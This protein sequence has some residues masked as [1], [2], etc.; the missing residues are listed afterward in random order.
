ML[1]LLV[2][3]WFNNK[4]IT[5][6]G[7]LLIIIPVIILVPCFGVIPFIVAIV[8]ML[9]EAKNWY[10]FERLLCVNSNDNCV[11]GSV[12]HEPEVST[13][14]DRKM[15][16]LLAPFTEEECFKKIATHLNANNVLLNNPA[17]FNNPP[18][19]TGLVAQAPICDADILEDP[20]ADGAERRAERK[21]IA[22]YL[23]IIKGTDPADGDAT[24]NI[25]NNFLVGYMDRLLDPG[26]TNANGEPKN[27]QGRYYRKD[28]AII[29]PGSA[30]SEAIPPDY[31]SNISWQAADSSISPLTKNNP[32]E[33]TF[34]PRGLNTMFRFDKD[35]LL[36]YLHC[37]I[38]G[39]YIAILLD[40]LS[41]ALVSFGIAYTFACM[42]LGPL[43]G[44][45]IGALFAFLVWLIQFFID[46]GSDAGDATEPDVEYDDPDNFGENGQQ[47]DGDLVGIYGPWI[48]DTE[49][50]QYFEIHPVKAYYI[51][52]RNG[53]TGSIDPFDSK[54][55][56][57]SSGAE[58]L[59]NSVI[60]ASL[61]DE[62][63][64]LITKAE[65]EDIPVTIYRTV[66][67][68]L[69]YGLKSYYGGGGIQV[70]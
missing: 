39:Y 29:S 58:R 65:N 34:Q 1:G 50:A 8:A 13:D 66:P 42:I 24:S 15:D 9:Q 40:Q 36:P 62:I 70:N 43:F 17:T 23:E 37:E 53:R 59:D 12:L 46:G 41:L 35:R 32:Y 25:F 44:L 14:G 30:L 16:L 4:A 5:I 21:K 45:L 31:D 63:C 38:D 19:F 60:T 51:L 56:R 52:A 3:S 22:D 49:H 69:S 7:A 61:K 11:V 48:M 55:D 28:P 26:N 33:V 10:Y 18:F 64:G 68:I 6:A 20:N 57:E 2:S 54:N 47:L 27:F 67:A